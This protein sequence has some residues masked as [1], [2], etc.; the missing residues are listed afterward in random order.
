MRKVLALGLLLGAASLLVAA[1][2]SANSAALVIR[3]TGC[4]LFDGDGISTVADTDQAVVTS[5]GALLTC[6][7]TGVAN[8]TGRA[9]HYDPDNNPFFPGLQCGITD[10]EGG[11][12]LTTQW[13]ETVSASGNATLTCHLNGP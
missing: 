2:T 13:K 5:S 7:V 10:G 9:V 6:K 12:L 11:F 8:S 3:D 1:Q 4:N